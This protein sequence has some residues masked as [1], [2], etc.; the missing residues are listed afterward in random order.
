[1]AAKMS[2]LSKIDDEAFPERTR[3]AWH[4]FIDRCTPR[5]LRS[6][7]FM[8]TGAVNDAMSAAVSDITNIR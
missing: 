1:M 8:V 3:A 5:A 6:I 7:A 2:E 4:D